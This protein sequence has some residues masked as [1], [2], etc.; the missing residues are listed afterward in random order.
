MERKKFT[1]FDGNL[2]TTNKKSVKSLNNKKKSFANNPT[3]EGRRIIWAGFLQREKRIFSQFIKKET[4]LTLRIL[5]SMNCIYLFLD[6]RKI[7]RKRIT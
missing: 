7:R 3:T 4:P 5:F 6:I 1:T 2:N